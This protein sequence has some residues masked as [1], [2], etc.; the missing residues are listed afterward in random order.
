MSN[1]IDLHLDEI[2][3][4][5][6][7]H[8][9]LLKDQNR[10][11]T[12]DQLVLII[13]H[14]FQ[15]TQFPGQLKTEL[16]EWFENI[17]QQAFIKRLIH[18]KIFEE[19]IFHRHDYIQIIYRGE[20]ENQYINALSAEDFQRALQYW[21]VD[22]HLNW[23]HTHPFCSFDYHYQNEDYRVTL[24]HASTTP[25]NQSKVFIRKHQNH[26]C[27]LENFTNDQP[28]KNLILEMISKK[29]NV[30]IAG[31]TGSG[32]TSLMKTMMT[33]INESE[34]I[35]VLEDTHELKLD[36]SNSTYL[37]SKQDS[38]KK[39]L[40]DYCSY[41]MR[42]SPDRLLIGELR[43]KEVI[44]FILAMNTGHKGLMST[45]HANSAKDTI[46]RLKM[47]FCIYGDNQN[48]NSI[49]VTDLICKNLEII[50]F[51]ENK[52]IK[53]IIKIYGS[54]D[55]TPFFETLYLK[56]DQNTVSDHHRFN[57]A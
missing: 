46:D 9:Y 4:S 28:A 37:L 24:I 2:K 6:K 53:E 51:V 42:M 14:E 55:E 56:T 27:Y 3:T 22:E 35:I 21:S 12:F 15:L 36:H 57:I 41:A 5:F 44:P 38:E 48:I 50:V 47:L 34:H 40:T 11:I 25:L 8:Y 32:K 26:L 16:V 54:E 33:N 31:A 19:I 10:F 30:I 45:I 49:F 39:S 18:E 20:K 7:N 17:H 52:S 1:L 13:T 29:A 23:N 43:S